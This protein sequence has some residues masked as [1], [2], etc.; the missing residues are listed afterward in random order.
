MKCKRFLSILLILALAAC[1]PATPSMP[2]AML[3]LTDTAAPPPSPTPDS[4]ADATESD[5]R[6]RFTFEQIIPC[7][8]TIVKVAAFTANNLEYDPD[9]DHREHGS[10]EYVPAGIVYQRG[11]DDGDGHAILQ[12]YLLEK[13]SL[14]AFILGLSIDSPVGSNAC[15]I[16]V[17]GGIQVL[18][19]G[20]SISPIFPSMNELAAY[21]TKLEWMHPGGVIRSLK[22]S[23]VTGVTTDATL[24]EL[25]WVIIP[26][27]IQTTTPD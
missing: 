10:N 26:Y 3:A 15:G 21:Y 12:C 5:A 19:G 13:N 17:D 22:A 18:E 7:L 23:Q 1:A 6:Q 11:I 27:E 4:C 16:N 8:D 2:T 9:Y 24:M 25:P 14:D 20:G